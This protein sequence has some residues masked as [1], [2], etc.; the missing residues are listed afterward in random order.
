M[1]AAGG[2]SRPDGTIA[3]IVV[4]YGAVEELAACVASLTRQEGAPLARLILVDNN[5]PGERCDLAPLREAA[6]DACPLEIAAPGENLGYGRAINLALERVHEE[7]VLVANPDLILDPAALARLRDL[8]RERP[9]AGAAGP[10]IVSLDGRV[11][12]DLPRRAPGLRD[13][14][15]GLAGWGRGS[16][17]GRGRRRADAGAKETLPIGDEQAAKDSE[18]AKETV[19]A[20]YPEAGA[21]ADERVGFLSGAC[22]LARRAALEQVG[23]FDPRFFLYYEDADLFRR[24]Q[25]AG[26]DLHR[27]A[28]AVARHAQGGSWSDPVRRQAAGLRGALAYHAKHGGRPGALLFRAALLGLYAPRLLAGGL[29]G[30]VLGIRTGFDARQRR[31]MLLETVRIAFA[32][33]NGPGGVAAGRSS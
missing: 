31:R 10:R 9:Q 18:A 15:A 29:L 32:R 3:G 21:G 22:F 33:A 28:N 30:G 23:G 1:T 27:V 17:A 12:S 25:A 5:P 8:L 13:D 20:G 16:A 7:Y 14:L 2:S 11:E 24:M 6:G 26:W 4:C 19:A